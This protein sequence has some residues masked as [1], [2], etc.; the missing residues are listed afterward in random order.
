MKIGYARVST[1][2]QS[3]ETQ[4]EKLQ[5]VGCEKI[6]EEKQTGKSTDKR[7]ELKKALEYVREGDTLY[8]TKLDRLARSLKD[9][10]NI[11]DT[12]DRKSVGFVVIDQE[13][14]TTTPTGKLIFHVIGAIGEFERSLIIERTQE[15]R[16]KAKV[17]GRKFG[18]KKALTDEQLESLK[19]QVDAGENS[20]RELAK[21]Y[22]IG[23]STLYRLIKSL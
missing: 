7:E 15:G 8:I 12:L 9:L 20:K 4:R 13:I 10:T 17:Q 19:A 14:N 23:E 16:A 11:A 2:G 3:L 22:G 21:K 6:F 18:R 5:Q 1:T